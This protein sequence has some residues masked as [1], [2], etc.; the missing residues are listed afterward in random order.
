[1][2]RLLAVLA[3]C[4]AAAVGYGFWLAWPPLGFI[5]SGAAGLAFAL[6]YDTGD[7]DRRGS[8]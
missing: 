5:V 8:E 7:K 1:M 6:L 3:L 4:S 2:T